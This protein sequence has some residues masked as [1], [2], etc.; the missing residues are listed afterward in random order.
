[1][2]N[3]PVSPLSRSYVVIGRRGK[4][5]TRFGARLMVDGMETNAFVGT[6]GHNEEVDT[7]MHQTHA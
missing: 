4:G 7:V 3:S 6:A 1:L 2:E 5:Q